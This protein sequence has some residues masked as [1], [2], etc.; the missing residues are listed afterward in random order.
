MQR[1]RPVILTALAA[2]LTFTP[3]THSVFWGSMASALIG[4][5][6]AGT[7][8]I[9]LFLPVLSA[10]WS[11]QRGRGRDVPDRGGS[12][13]SSRD[14]RQGTIC[15]IACQR[16]PQRKTRQDGT[17]RDLEGTLKPA[18]VASLEPVRRE[19]QV[20]GYEVSEGGHVPIDP[21]D[22]AA[23][24]PDSGKV[25]AVTSFLRCREVDPVYFDKPYYLAPG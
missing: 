5:T 15:L 19:D 10:A 22:I 11:L 6:G 25:T 23:V 3:L 9:L 24:M 2:V 8:P 20:E 7:V 1:T 14:A 17:A 18:V 16:L 13:V 21:E 12:A 4:G